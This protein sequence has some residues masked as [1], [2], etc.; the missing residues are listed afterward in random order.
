MVELITLNVLFVLNNLQRYVFDRPDL[1]L[2]EFKIN[3][4]YDNMKKLVEN[5]I[6]KFQ[7]S[8]LCSV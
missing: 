4:V 6:K 3:A 2:N 1:N 8:L 7:K 5:M